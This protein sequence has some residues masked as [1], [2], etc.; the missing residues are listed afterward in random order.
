MS[1][2]HRSIGI[3]L[4]L[5]GAS[6]GTVAAG[7]RADMDGVWNLAYESARDSAATGSP[8][9][10]LSRAGESERAAYDFLTDDPHMQCIPASIS[11]IML[12]PSPLFEIR[13]HADHVEIN[14]E[15]MDVKR[16]VPLDPNQTLEDAPLTAPQFPHLGRS[17]GRYE[18]EELV[19]QTTDLHEGVFST[20]VIVGYPNSDQMSMVE[21]YIPD[22]ERME[23]RIT[24]TDP[25]Y[26]DEPFDILY[27]YV[28]SPYPLLEWGCVPEKAC[29]DPREC[30]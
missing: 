9:I 7:V 8:P 15:F 18:G 17:I 20:H 27:Q 2:T 26:Y 5:L 24:H 10:L 3:G 21:R 19:I 11:R 16:R 29:V 28:R 25:V 23:V 6:S 14:Y 1:L 30:N 13:Q 12:T 22:G 4:A